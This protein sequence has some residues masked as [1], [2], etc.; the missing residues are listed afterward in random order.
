VSVV[1]RLVSGEVFLC[2]SFP[3]WLAVRLVADEEGR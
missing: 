3:L 1:W 2:G